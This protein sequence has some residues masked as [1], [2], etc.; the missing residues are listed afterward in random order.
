M[1]NITGVVG[2]GQDISELKSV[3]AE[4]DARAAEMTA[5]VEGANAPIISVDRG[6]N[7]KLWNKFTEKL[8]GFRA[9]DALGK[10]LV[11]SFIEPEDRTEVKE[12]LMMALNEGK[13]TSNYQIPLYTKDRKRLEILFNATPKRNAENEIVGVIGVGQDIT[14]LKH[15]QMEAEVRAIE[16][17]GLVEGATRR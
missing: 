13:Q 1:A 8:T 6:L 17:T 11:D 10:K 5:L 2:V 7:V 15:A 16:L 12:I 4:S 14:D 3:Q 9:E